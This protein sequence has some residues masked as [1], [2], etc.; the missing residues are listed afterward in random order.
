MATWKKKILKGS[1]RYGYLEGVVDEPLK[2]SQGSDHDD[3]WTESSPES[4]EAELFDKTSD[5]SIRILVQL[6]D[7]GVRR[8]GDHGTEH[9]GDVSGD[10]GHCELL[11]LGALSTGLRD[12]VLVEHLDSLLEACELHHSVRDLARPQRRQ[13]LEESLETLGF[14]D[15]RS[16]STE[17]RRGGR[18]RL[19]TDLDSFHRG[20]EDVCEELGGRRSSEVDR[21]SPDVGILFSESR[22]VDVLEDLVEAELSESLC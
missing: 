11:G 6:R 10:E 15:H 22:T 14:V 12:D 13:T 20:Q 16:A 17:S 2:G 1:W 21:G 19:H 9:S 18:R 5:G 4:H 3:S 8:M 7:E